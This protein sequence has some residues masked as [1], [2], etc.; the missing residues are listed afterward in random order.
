[1]PLFQC[2]FFVLCTEPRPL[3]WLSSGLN[4]SGCTSLC[5]YEVKVK[6]PLQEGGGAAKT[7]WLGAL[8]A[9]MSRV[10]LLAGGQGSGLPAQ[11][12][13][14]AATRPCVACLTLPGPQLLDLWGWH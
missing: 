6:S 9:E 3:A 7:D 5:R 11:E 13:R 8:P 4:K 2:L 1:M 10:G 12:S 14:P